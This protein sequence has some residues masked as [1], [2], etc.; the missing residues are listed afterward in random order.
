MSEKLFLGFRTR[1]HHA[2][3]D[4]TS[5]TVNRWISTGM[6]AASASSSETAYA[7]WKVRSLGMVVFEV[8]RRASD[9]DRRWPV[10]PRHSV[11]VQ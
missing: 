3:D 8:A 6:L 5:K 4:K 2:A 11:A 1:S 10:W 7:T 9:T